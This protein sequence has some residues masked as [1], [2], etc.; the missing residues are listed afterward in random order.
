MTPASVLVSALPAWASALQPWIA[1]AP[2]AALAA[3]AVALLLRGVHASRP[4]VFGA[5]AWVAAAIALAPFAATVALTPVPGALVPPLVAALAAALLARDPEDRAQTEA[6]LK[7]TW[8]LGVAFALSWA[9]ESLLAVAAGSSRPLEQWPALALHLDP[10]GLWTSALSLSLVA[11]IV[12][13][14]GA[15]FHFWIADLAHGARAWIA[16]LAAAAL[17]AAGAAWVLRRLDG[18]GA[19]PAGASLAASLLGFTCALAFVA[20]AATLA[21]QRRPERR[22]G[23]LAS[24]HGALAL[25]VLAAT[26]GGVVE[27]PVGPPG[28]LGG[29]A[30][31]LALA[32][33][34]ATALAHFLPV[35]ASET[36]PP[37]PLFRRHPLVA[38]V[39]AYSLLSLAGAPGTPGALVWL[40]AARSLVV[41]RHPGLLVALAVAWL[42]AFAVAAGELRRAFG[43][44]AQGPPPERAVP[45]PAQAALATAGLALAALGAWWWR[46]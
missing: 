25:A 30:A 16:P 24:L 44:R 2:L 42:V 34:G 20:G 6:A 15:P 7:L 38:L 3:L 27:L 10:Y 4:G 9:G 14:G 22:V 39:G 43:V 8:V 5:L 40:G 31:H 18:I 41:T 28:G 13:M 33:S 26:R 19:F 35:G 45:W 29:W 37:V 17:Q 36:E 1:P 46:G 32:L 23:T 12:L 11:G 21:T